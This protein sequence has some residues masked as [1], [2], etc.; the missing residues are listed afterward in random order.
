LRLPRR[1]AAPGRCPGR[2]RSLG[3][4]PRPPWV[5]GRARGLAAAP[6]GG[7]V[8][9]RDPSLPCSLPRGVKARRGPVD[10]SYWARPPE[11]RGRARRGL[12]RKGRPPPFRGAGP[13]AGV[14]PS[15]QHMRYQ[16]RQTRRAASTSL[17]RVRVAT[18][19]RPAPPPGG[20]RGADLTAAGACLPPRLRPP[21]A[22]VR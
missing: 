19:R 12:R 6:G 15:V 4:E 13:A 16:A 9:G 7:T 18:G 14:A 2:R 22:T 11:G 10:A 21:C 5:R 20:G 3:A 17:T 1:D 8:A